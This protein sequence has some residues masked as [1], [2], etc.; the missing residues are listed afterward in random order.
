MNSHKIDA[1]EFLKREKKL[2]YYLKNRPS[3]YDIAT[4]ASKSCNSFGDDGYIFEASWHVEHGNGGLEITVAGNI[5]INREGEFTFYSYVLCVC[6]DNVLLRKYHYDYECNRGRDK[7]MFHLQYGGLP[8]PSLA[9]Y[10]GVEELSAWLSEPRLFYTPMS[11]A[12]ILEQVF[13]EFPNDITNKIQQDNSWKGHVRE[14]Q[15]ALLAPYFELCKKKII[16]NECLY[17]DCYA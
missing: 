6:K 10:G 14:S 4:A 8:L 12:L 2:L 16:D 17:A 15:K 7:P 3:A 1:K 9:S 5:E 13:L 11:L